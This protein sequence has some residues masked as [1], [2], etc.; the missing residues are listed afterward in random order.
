MKELGRGKIGSMFGELAIRDPNHVRAASVKCLKDCIFIA[1]TGRDFQR[2][3]RR[4]IEKIED[5]KINFLQSTAVFGLW[6]KNLCRTFLCNV[7]TQTFCKGSQIIAQ[8]QPSNPFLYLVKK[9]SVLL[10]VQMKKPFSEVD[11]DVNLLQQEKYKIKDTIHGIQRQTNE[12]LENLNCAIEG[13]GSGMMGACDGWPKLPLTSQQYVERMETQRQKYDKDQLKRRILIQDD[14]KDKAMMTRREY[15]ISDHGFARL[16]EGHTFNEEGIL[17]KEFPS[18]YTVVAASETVEIE[19]INA[20]QLTKRMD[21]IA[22][23]EAELLSVMQGKARQLYDVC[24]TQASW[25][26][27]FAD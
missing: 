17:L 21:Q 14:R 20:F 16:E 13:D 24:R 18:Q 25:S 26:L 15:T 19:V 10:Q 8:G 5:D 1:L 9:G 3:L 6:S 7:K 27:V 23:T 2:Y 11:A 4:V 12:S 22:G